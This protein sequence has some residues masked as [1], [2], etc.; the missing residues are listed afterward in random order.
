MVQLMVSRAQA[1]IGPGDAAL[2]NSVQGPAVQ[3]YDA[4]NCK[5]PPSP[6]LGVQ[7]LALPRHVKTHP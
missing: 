7:F 5:H 2:L 4:A 1:C 3:L 6:A